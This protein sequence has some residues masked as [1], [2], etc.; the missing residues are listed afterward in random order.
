MW[1]LL[2]PLWGGGF[3]VAFAQ[4]AGFYYL[5][6]ALLHWVL[7]ALLRPASIQEAPRRPGEVGRDALNSLGE[8]CDEADA[9]VWVVVC[10][11]D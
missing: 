3:L 7:P 2:P 4:A 11:V 9:G 8:C 5:L 10:C 6:G 1:R